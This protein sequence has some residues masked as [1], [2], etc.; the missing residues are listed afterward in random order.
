MYDELVKF[1]SA[2]NDDIFITGA[3]DLK[4]IN[5]IEKEL[6]ICIIYEYKQF[7]NQFGMIMGYGITILGCGKGGQPPVVTQTLRYRNLGLEKKYFVICSADEWIYCLN[8]E[9]NE[10]SS[11]D[12][13]VQC[14]KI[15][16]ASFSEFLLMILSDAKEN[17]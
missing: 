9:T 6:G 11:W 12:A 10:V 15:E 14:H 1:I 3:V 8:S 16:S 4:K 7:L 5:Q 17:W 13:I 2:N